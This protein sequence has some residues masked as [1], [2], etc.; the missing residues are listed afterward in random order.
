MYEYKDLYT[1]DFTNVRYYLEMHRVIKEAMDWPDYYGENWDAFWD[2]LRYMTG[3][4]IHI[5]IIGL[6]V[7]D[8]KFPGESEIMIGIFKEFK[9][10]DHD[11]YCHEINIEIVSGDTRVSLS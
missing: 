7:I 8:R 5:E 10:S 11:K 3:D 9:H 1:I 4:P 6:E 2:C